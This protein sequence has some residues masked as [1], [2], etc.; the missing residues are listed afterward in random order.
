MREQNFLVKLIGKFEF[1]EP[2]L[3]RIT[4]MPQRCALWLTLKSVGWQRGTVIFMP[5]LILGG[6]ELSEG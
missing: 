6:T 4:Q 5:F 3:N 2:Q 1:R